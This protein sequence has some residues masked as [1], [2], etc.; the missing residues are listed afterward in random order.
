MSSSFSWSASMSMNQATL[1]KGEETM[2]V[3]A[4]EQKRKLETKKTYHNSRMALVERDGGRGK[5]SA[6]GVTL[7]AMRG[8]RRT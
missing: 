1:G 4:T 5:G 3:G 7:K 2:S 6:K 8:G